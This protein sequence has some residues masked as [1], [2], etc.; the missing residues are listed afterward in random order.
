MGEPGTHDDERQPRL[1]DLVA[2]S[3]QGGD[4]V[5]LEVLHLVDEDRDA[6]SRV[7]RH[8]PEVGEQLDEVDL[9]VA[10]VG[11]AG[12]GG[13]ADAGVPPVA[14]LRGGPA[15]PRA[16]VALALAEGLDDAEGVVTGAAGRSELTH[17]LV[18]GR[19]QGATQRLVG[20][21]LELAG[22]PARADRGRAQRVEQ[23][24]LAHTPQAGED[25]GPLRPAAR[26]ALQ[27]D[28]EGVELLVAPGQLGRSLAGA[29]GVGVPDGVHDRSVC[30]SLAWIADIPIEA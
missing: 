17:G 21:G 18:H 12:D 16:R 7:R 15:A 29:G 27:D 3:T 26:H 13:N 19:G 22:A 1:G 6:P 23:H 24:R 25:D 11:P 28:V 8:A 5:G 10:G 2:R 9:D 20:A 30:G 14:Q 4:V